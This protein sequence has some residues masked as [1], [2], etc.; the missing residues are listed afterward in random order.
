[1][2]ITDFHLVITA[3]DIIFPTWSRFSDMKERLRFQWGEAGWGSAILLLLLIWFC[4]Q[5]FWSTCVQGVML[6]WNAVLQDDYLSVLQCLG[7]WYFAVYIGLALEKKTHTHLFKL[8]A[9]ELEN[10]SNIGFL[11]LCEWFISLLRFT[12]CTSSLIIFS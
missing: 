10:K 3:W 8:N 9:L 6:S 11:A 5:L 1:M 7:Q 4:D 2:S 12:S